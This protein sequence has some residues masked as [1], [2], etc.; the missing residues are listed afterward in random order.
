[1]IPRRTRVTW[2]IGLVMAV[3]F[4]ALV[5]PSITTERWFGALGAGHVEKGHRA[6]ITVRV[7]LFAGYQ[8]RSRPHHRR[9]RA[10]RARRAA[11][12]RQDELDA[13]DIDDAVP[14]G[15][16]PYIAY[17]LLA[18]VLAGLFTHHMRRSN[19]G[20]LLRAQLVS[21][22]LIAVGAATVKAVMLTTAVSVLVVPVAL[23]AMVPTLALDR[24]V[25]LATGTLSALV[26]SLLVPFDVGVAVVLLVQVAVA[27]LVIAERPKHAWKATLVA[28]AVATACS[29]LVYPLLDVPD[30]RLPAVRRARPPAALAVAR[31][32]ASVPR[33]RPRSR[34]H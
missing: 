25:G 8:T 14:Q 31:V 30:R 28:G 17:F 9:R 10:D 24:V 1:M 29:A 19:H 26:V 11:R 23:F 21:L 34:C 32:R 3:A 7:P 5:V 20:R 27:G 16:F 22:A 15:P 12:P 13:A 2:W 33:S 6:A 4:A 18:S